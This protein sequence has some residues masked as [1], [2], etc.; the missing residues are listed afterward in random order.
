MNPRF[1]RSLKISTTAH[2]I[3]LLLLLVLPSIL[4][5]FHRPKPRDIMMVDLLNALPPGPP[6]PQGPAAQAE[7]KAPPAPPPAPDKKEEIAEKP[8]IK[9]NT[10]RVKR[11]EVV[12]KQLPAPKKPTLSEAEVRKLLSAGLPVGT[13]SASAGGGGGGGGGDPVTWY[14]AQVR[15]ALYEAW[16][17]PSAATAVGLSA[18]VSIRVQRDGTITKRNLIRGSGNSQMDASVM[19]ALD[20]VARL[21]PLP[22]ELSGPY[23][24]ITVLFEPAGV[25]ML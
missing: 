17:P 5:F 22:P 8:R 11:A 19:R 20:S 10:N 9:I 14:Y 6:G 16:E 4:N 13:T 18:Q 7:V 15:A 24:D 21:K 2:A 12:Q 1:R 23:Q 3:V 25:G